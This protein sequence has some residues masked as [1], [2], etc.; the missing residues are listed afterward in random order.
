MALQNKW[1]QQGIRARGGPEAPPEDDQITF[2]TRIVCDRP[3]ACVVS[4]IWLTFH[5]RVSPM[6]GD[7]H[8]GAH[9]TVQSHPS[10]VF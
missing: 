9:H 6:R 5:K 8:T 1:V 2:A 10:H 3:K 7:L 4:P